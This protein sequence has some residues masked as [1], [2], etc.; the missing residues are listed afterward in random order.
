MVLM[1]FKIT[2]SNAKPINTLFIY[3]NGQSENQ[4]KTKY[5]SLH[6]QIHQYLLKNK[7]AQHH[8]QRMPLPVSLKLC[9]N[10]IAKRSLTHHDPEKNMN[11]FQMPVLKLKLKK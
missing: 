2:G 10:R 9:L 1:A 7:I 5:C 6:H 8:S 3:E 11:E 4:K